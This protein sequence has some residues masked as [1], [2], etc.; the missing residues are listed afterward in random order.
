MAS[1][2]GGDNGKSGEPAKQATLEALTDPAQADMAGMAQGLVFAAMQRTAGPL[3]RAAALARVP[4][5]YRSYAAQMMGGGAGSDGPTRQPIALKVTNLSGEKSEQDKHTTA[6][7]V[8]VPGYAVLFVFFLANSVAISLITERQEGTLRRMLS[9]PISRNQILF[10]KL[11][12]RGFL[13]ILQIAMLF[14]VGRAW[15]HFELGSSIPGLILTALSTI[16][17]A[18]GLG[19][20]IATFGKNLGADRGHD[21]A[22]AV[23]NGR[24]IGLHDAAH[25]AAGI[26]AEDQPRHA[27]CLGADRLSGFDFAAITACRGPSQYRRRR[28]VR[29]RILRR[30]ACPL[31]LRI[32]RRKHDF[33]GLFSEVIAVLAPKN[34]GRGARAHRL[35]FRRN[36]RLGR[37]HH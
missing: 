24:H 33:K 37:R 34:V 20:L 36:A 9:A 2:A 32:R 13:G 27:P 11:L 35:R 12:A 3:Y 4:E 6:G 21:F 17:A 29:S 31:P 15:L 30:R 8:M 10:G 18:T 26:Y 5:D 16:F 1:G 19:L 7:N 22:G 25:D 28:P 14:A 23:C